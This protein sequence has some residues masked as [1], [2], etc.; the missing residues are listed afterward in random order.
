M[1]G[2][3]HPMH[4]ML[5]A[6]Q[7]GDRSSTPEFEGETSESD[8]TCDEVAAASLFG[9]RSGSFRIPARNAAQKLNARLNDTLR[10]VQDTLAVRVP[11]DDAPRLPAEQSGRPILLSDA[12]TLMRWT[13]DASFSWRS[14]VIRQLL[15]LTGR[16]RTILAETR[17]DDM[18]FDAKEL[19]SAPETV[20]AAL[21]RAVKRADG[22]ATAAAAL[23]ADLLGLLE[24][25]KLAAEQAGCREGVHEVITPG[26]SAVEDL[27]VDG[28]DTARL[29]VDAPRLLV[30]DWLQDLVRAVRSLPGHESRRAHE[31]TV[32]PEPVRSPSV[33][34][35]ASTGRPRPAAASRFLRAHLGIPVEPPA[36]ASA[37]SLSPADAVVVI[38][39]P[40]ASA[41]SPENLGLVTSLVVPRAGGRAAAPAPT[42]PGSLSTLDSEMAGPIDEGFLLETVEEAWLGR[43]ERVARERIVRITRA[44]GQSASLV[45]ANLSDWLRR[46]ADLAIRVGVTPAGSGHAS[47]TVRTRAKSPLSET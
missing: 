28:M 37:S 6:R 5:L 2:A 47:M 38:E 44:F 32:P 23:R 9:S 27:A 26:Y 46:N 29:A 22:M 43:T 45:R 30:P 41:A 19:S 21:E 31:S 12:R 35:P 36:P 13:A 10:R 14:N 18:H 4:A 34:R 39:A 16:A 42:R 24:D 17:A 8:R 15:D 11:L 33:D 7:H 40:T 3:A 25:Q 1:A 20:V